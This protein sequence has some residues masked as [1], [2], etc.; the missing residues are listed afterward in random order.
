MAE[1]YRNRIY[2]RI[3]PMVP[4]AVRLAVRRWISRRK[5]PEV[6]NVWPIAP[7]SERPPENWKGWPEGKKFALV[8]T[9]DVEGEDGLEKCRRLMELET[10]LGFRSSFNFIPEGKYRVSP[11]LR[12]EVA[13]RGF[14]VGVHDLKHDGRLYRNREHFGRNA[15]SINNYLKDWNAGGFRSG[16][17]LHNLN[18]LHD[19]NIEYDASTFDTDPFEPQ[20][21]SRNTIFPFWVS[22]GHGGYAELPYTLPQDSTLFLLLEERDP[23]IWIQK[24]DWI[25]RHGGMALMNVHP[26]YMRFPGDRPTPRTFPVEHYAAL[27]K[28]LRDQYAGSYWHPLPREMAKFVRE[29]KPRLSATKSRRVCMITHSFYENDNRVTRYAEALAQRGDEVDVLAL[30]RGPE[31]PEV[32]VMSGVRVHRLQTRAGKNEKT[33]LD[34][35]WPL[36]RFLTVSSLWLRRNHRAKPYDLIHVHNIPDFM[37]FAA[38]YPKLKGAQVLLDIHDIVPEFYG[39]KFGIANDSLTVQSL[40]KMERASAKFA[41]HVILANHLWLEKYASRS[42]PTGKCS[43]FINN[44]DSDIFQRGERS[45]RDEKQIILFPGGLQ[46]HQGIDI[47]IQAFHKIAGQVPNAEFH[48]Y[49]D[50]NMKPKLIEL[51]AELGLKDRIRF[52]E[53]LR[54]RQIAKVMADADLGVVPKRAD[55]FGNEAYSTKIMEFMSV[56][57]PVVISSTKIDRFYFNDSVVRF[58]ESGNVDALAQGMLDL[59][60]NPELRN[61]MVQRATQYVA[62]NSWEVRKSDYLALVDSICMSSRSRN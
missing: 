4:A 41:D 15:G 36:L 19:L 35:L 16:F 25:A 59:L 40:K 30:R 47:A 13:S 57:V 23:K 37:V 60:K 5:F 24:L 51:V 28:H 46:W 50:G 26:D 2:Y 39:S 49:G 21:D 48:I 52:F 3:K 10:S 43:V 7:G 12:A 38:W 6:Q 54:I 11:E 14:E 8:L 58:F 34:F 18:W 62:Q 20:P 44:V 33:K 61:E 56:G 9:H 45:R 31:M 29:T 27:L 1:R 17:M 53:P 42:A 22:N 32:E 55:S